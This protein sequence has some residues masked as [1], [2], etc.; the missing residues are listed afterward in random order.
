MVARSQVLHPRALTIGVAV[1]VGV[2]GVA[3]GLQASGSSVA[4]VPT[5][6]LWVAL[7]P[8][9]LGLVLGGYVKSI[10]VGPLTIE[11]KLKKLAVVARTSHGVKIKR[12][13]VSISEEG[14]P[15]EWTAF[16]AHEYDESHNIQLVHVYRPSKTRKYYDISIYLMKHVTGD[17]PNQTTRLNDVT[18]AEFYFGE[19]WGNRVFTPK[20]DYG[21]P[22]GV[23]ISAWGMFLAV[24][25]LTFDDDRTA[26]VYRYIDFEM[27]QG[28]GR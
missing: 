17:A 19:Y 4:H 28:A 26:I 8:V 13:D 12:G 1:A 25:R 18:N 2:L 24:C 15:P 20:I 10:G 14:T 27:E 21:R 23:N 9:L 7:V 22:I 5:F 6:W 16:R 3:M 11:T